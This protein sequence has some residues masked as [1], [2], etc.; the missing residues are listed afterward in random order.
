MSQP[1]RT[2]ELKRD[3]DVSAG[4]RIKTLFTVIIEM[5]PGGLGP[6]GIGDLATALEGLVGRTM[7]GL[8]LSLFE[9]LL[10]FIA[11]AIPVV[12][13]RPVISAYRWMTRPKSDGN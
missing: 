5:I 11:S 6:Y 9:R 13:A 12:P 7:D 8:K 10:Y 4:Q 1:Q 2:E 3:V